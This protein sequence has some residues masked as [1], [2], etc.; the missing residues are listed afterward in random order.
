MENISFKDGLEE[1]VLFCFYKDG[2]ILLED[3]G[4]GF[5]VEA[6]YPNGGIE[7]KDK[8]NDN[9][10][11]NA[12]HREI[13][14]EFNNQININNHIY[15][16]DVVVTDINAIFYVYLITDWTGVFPESIKEPG[17]K[18]SLIS[19]FNIDEAKELFNYESAFDILE[20]IVKKIW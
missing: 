7:I 11:I 5:N 4:K 3:R 9:Y 15:C 6:F 18:D 16:G 14:E 1:A 20:L 2:K 13:K 8:F 19:F 12:L 17:E 10:I